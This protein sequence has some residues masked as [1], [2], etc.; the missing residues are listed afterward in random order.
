VTETP[1]AAPGL[2][3]RKPPI[4]DPVEHPA[5]MFAALRD[6]LVPAHPPTHNTIEGWGGWKMLGNGPDP[7]NAANGV[8]KA[9]AGDCVAVT[10]ATYRRI[11]T[12]RRVY[13]TLAQVIAF[14]K[15]QN[16]DFPS[17]DDGMVIQTALETLVKEGGPDGVKAIAFAKVDHTNAEEMRAAL[18]LFECLWMGVNVTD[19]N[20]QDFPGEWTRA[21]TVE[22]GHSITGVGYLS[23]RFPI[24]TWATDQCALSIDYVTDGTARTAG[25]EE[26][27]L[28]VWP[29]DVENLTAEGRDALA[30]NYTAL[31]GREI[32][33]PDTPGPF[34]PPE[35]TPTPDPVVP[36]P[37][38][39]QALAGALTRVLA[40]KTCPAYLRSAAGPWLAGR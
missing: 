3:G 32:T 36:V 9:G 34:Q 19:Q 12:K 15:T 33:W 20:M 14:Y 13:P 27:W 17:Q 35:P 4:Y 6:A 31:T 1:T 23:D 5:I 11:K 21:G 38:V 18:Y 26:A 22:G 24:E 29:E 8:P 2:F 25:L 39:D 28:V 10:W 16:P 40:T 37:D 30:A 7:E